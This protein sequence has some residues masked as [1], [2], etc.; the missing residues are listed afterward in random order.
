[1][2]PH[3]VGEASS[4][5]PDPFVRKVNALEQIMINK[6]LELA[7]QGMGRRSI[8]KELGLSEWSVRMML[9][10]KRAADE[11][12]PAEK[13][14]EKIDIAEFNKLKKRKTFFE[15]VGQ[16]II[17]AVK[18]I[19]P[20]KTL[21]ADKLF[22]KKK[23]EPEEMMLL[24][25]DSQIGQL[26]DQKE[27]GGLGS[28]SVDVFLERLEFL[29]IS[30]KNIFEIHLDNT[31]YP[32]FN[33]FFLGDIIEGSTIFPGQERQTDLHA[34]QQVMFAVDK[35]AEFVAWVAA[36]Y[37]WKVKCFCVIGNH[38]RIGKKGEM[39]PLNNLDYLVYHY[40]REKLKQFKNVEFNISESWYMLVQKFAWKFLLVHGDDIRAWM[41]IPYYGLERSESRY[42]KMLS[43]YKTE[44][45]YFCCG[46]HHQ[47][48]TIKS[49][50]FM[51][52]NWVGGSELSMK[53]MQVA[54]S[55]TQLLFSVHPHF[56]VTW[57]RNIQLQDPAKRK[58]IRV[59]K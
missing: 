4:V 33:I 19:P 48:A 38:G 28:Y 39:S 7:R 10:G 53:I 46:H 13:M 17:S 30:L 15:I 44:F 36:L 40:C 43:D 23:H 12:T 11:R 18:S 3:G 21:P 29:K 35:I 41:G 1:M 42:Q 6:A 58:S 8:S 22:F 26:V 59:Y 54:N 16:D 24:W 27:S 32:V 57:E 52:G 47:E 55:P 14:R 34:V 51:N 37:P 49:R 5:S 9:E 45:H 25:S 2:S 56:G 50:I 20:P 31:P